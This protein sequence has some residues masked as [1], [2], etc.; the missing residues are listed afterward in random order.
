MESWALRGVLSGGW[1]GNL[2]SNDDNTRTGGGRRISGLEQGNITQHGC[3]RG[4]VGALLVVDGTGCQK[5]LVTISV[6]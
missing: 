4:R 5:Y 3:G 2:I 6:A 1:E